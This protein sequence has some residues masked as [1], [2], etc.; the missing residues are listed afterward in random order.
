MGQMSRSVAQTRR[1]GF[2]DGHVQFL[3]EDEF[4]TVLGGPQVAEGKP[5]Q[6]PG[7]AQAKAPAAAPAE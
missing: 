1:G 7:Q 4:V 3:S 6:N 5:P 2:L